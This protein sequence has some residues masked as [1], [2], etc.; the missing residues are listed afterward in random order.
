MIPGTGASAGAAGVL[1]LAAQVIHQVLAVDDEAQVVGQP[2]AG[3]RLL[4]EDAIL[5]VVV[6]DQ[7]RDRLAFRHLRPPVPALRLVRLVRCS[8][9]ERA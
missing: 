8:V 6:G 3:Q 7:D 5:L 9:P 4:R 2:C 1:A